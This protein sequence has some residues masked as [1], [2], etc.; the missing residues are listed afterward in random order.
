MSWT[1]PPPLAQVKQE[2]AKAYSGLVPSRS[3]SLLHTPC[4][5]RNGSEDNWNFPTR[6]TSTGKSW[7]PSPRKKLFV[8]FDQPLETN[9]IGNS[10]GPSPQ[11]TTSGKKTPEYQEPN[12]NSD[13][14]QSGE[15]RQTTGNP[16]GNM[17]LQD[18]YWPSRHQYVFKITELSELSRR[19]LLDQ[20]Q[21]SELVTYTGVQLVQESRALLG[22]EQVWTLT[23][24][25]PGQSFGAATV[26]KKMLSLMNFGV[27]STS[28]T[29]SDGWIVTQLLWRSKEAPLYFAP[30]RFGSPQI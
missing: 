9:P 19:T 28:R 14:N 29:C 22:N 1:P 4:P 16:S 30:K 3:T 20:I 6:D 10:R 24:K 11:T 2:D 23:L 25:I 13:A 27:E 5:V 7:S 12:L 17:P 18:V 21:W 8:S 15:T 26:A